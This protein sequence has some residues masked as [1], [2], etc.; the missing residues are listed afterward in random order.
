VNANCWCDQVTA[1]WTV[2]V[3]WNFPS[4]YAA[5]YTFP[6][7]GRLEYAVGGSWGKKYFDVNSLTGSVSFTLSGPFN[8]YNVGQLY[9]AGWARAYIAYSMFNEA[10]SDI[11]NLYLKETGSPAYPTVRVNAYVWSGQG[12][13]SPSG[14]ITVPWTGTTVTAT[15]APGY[16]F[17]EWVGSIVGFSKTDNPATPK[18]SSYWNQFGCDCLTA[19]Y[20]LGAMFAPVSTYWLSVMV[21]EGSGTIEAYRSDG[22]LLASTTGAT[23]SIIVQEGT[24]IYF[25]ATPSSGYELDRITVD[26]GTYYSSPTPTMTVSGN[27]YATAYFKRSTAK[28][29]L[30]VSPGGSGTLTFYSSSGQVIASTTTSTA[31][32]VKMGTQGYF[33]V[34]PASGYQFKNITIWG[35]AYY[36]NPTRNFTF[37]KDAFVQAN[38][39]KPIVAPPVEKPPPTVEKVKVYLCVKE[40]AGSISLYRSDGSRIIT[41]AN[42]QTVEV[43]KGMQGYFK[44]D[45]YQGYQFDR[46]V[47]NGTIYTVNPSPTFT[48][49]KDYDAQAY[50]KSVTA[51]LAPTPAPAPAP[52]P[53]VPWW[54]QKFLGIPAWAWIALTGGAAGIGIA[55]YHLAKKG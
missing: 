15:P 11:V 22:T 48:F 28:V 41:T 36:E 17:S 33:K 16:K 45:P 3:G 52:A 8:V 31:V 27:V 53:A 49:D 23:K 13:V 2:T 55:A 12:S 24:Q 14:V 4:S 6:W 21:G 20:G 25:K 19:T 44:A 46:F 34:D 40:G 39:A 7:K 1:S 32:E 18:A 35:T 43:E 51:P 54:E 9:E 38:L 30:T 42:W 47:I 26:G 10:A 29:S 5:I 50:F 37:D